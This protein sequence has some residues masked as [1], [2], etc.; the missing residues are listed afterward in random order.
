M[1]ARR[2][3]PA[4]LTVLL[5]LPARAATERSGLGDAIKGLGE[6][7]RR[8]AE[9]RHLEE[10]SARGLSSEG[11][12]T[13]D[14]VGALIQNPATR[15]LG[16]DLYMPRLGTP[17]FPRPTNVQLQAL[18]VEPMARRLG[19]AIYRRKVGLPPE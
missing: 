3:F 17:G 18:I 19:M 4:F 7:M 12:L 10:N 11:P 1:Y 16:L 14:Q 15:K 13:R 6:A 2:V 8:G 5:F 9:Q